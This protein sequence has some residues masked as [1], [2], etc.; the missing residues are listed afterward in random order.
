[1]PNKGKRGV[2]PIE[3]GGWGADPQDSEEQRIWGELGRSPDSERWPPTV[4]G[5]P[6]PDWAIMAGAYIEGSPGGLSSRVWVCLSQFLMNGG[7]GF[8]GGF[9][10]GTALS[11]MNTRGSPY[12][13]Q[14]AA[15]MGVAGGI[16]FLAFFGFGALTHCDDRPLTLHQQRSFDALHKWTASPV[17]IARQT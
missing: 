15:R 10:A 4:D 16:F 2:G 1:M 13:L 17:K 9:A 12:R 8:F 6:V 3:T 11:Y 7:L 5:K 14:K